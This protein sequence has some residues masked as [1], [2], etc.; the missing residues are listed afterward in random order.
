MQKK[1]NSKK[2]RS[3]GAE[4]ILA[5]AE[6][7]FAEKGFD[8]VN[9]ETIAKEANA[10]PANVFYHFKTK[11]QLYLAVLKAI[12]ERISLKLDSATEEQ[13]DLQTFL[14]AISDVVV[15][16]LSSDKLAIRFFMRELLGYGILN[17]NELAEKVM[18][19]S[20]K[21]IVNRLAECINSGQMRKDVDPV[22]TARILFASSVASLQICDQLVD[23]KEKTSKQLPGLYSKNVVDILLKG[24][25]GN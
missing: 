19:G 24:I 17:R 6:K 25:L 13:S 20:F 14:T 21:R 18:G 8:A 22:L 1:S 12:R 11:R 2:T 16:L 23:V 4:K 9:V 3:S 15:E 10:S 5:A 7:L